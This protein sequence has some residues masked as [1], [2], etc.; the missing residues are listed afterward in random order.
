VEGNVA[1]FFF[2]RSSK[3]TESL[4]TVHQPAFCFVAQGS[5][6]AQLAEEVF[7]YDPDHYMIFTVDLPL[8]FQI[9]KASEKRPCL[10]LRLNLDPALVASVMMESGIEIKKGD[11]D[12]KAMNVSSVDADLLDAVVRL[13]RLAERPEESKVLAPLVVRE[14]VFRLLAGGNVRG[15]PTC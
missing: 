3:P 15:S 12:T 7:H 2:T 11:A 5:K 9:K 1:G 6:R 14:I 8:I 10:G 4:N 13:V